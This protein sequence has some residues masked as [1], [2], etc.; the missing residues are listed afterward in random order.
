MATLKDRI[1]DLLSELPSLT[2]REITIRLMGP[3]VGQQA[4]NQATRALTASGK[5]I[6]RK[7]RDGKLGN[8]LGDPSRE[9]S[10]PTTIGTT[11]SE[12]VALSEDE[13]KLKL[14]KWLETKGWTVDVQLGR[15]RGIDVEATRDEAR[16]VIEA[17]GRG[18]RTQMQRNYF[19]EVLGALLL[20]MDDPNVR[21]SIALPDLK[22]FRNL[23]QSL[24]DLA[25][26]RT[27]ISA[28]FVDPFGSVEEMKSG[29]GPSV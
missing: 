23:W 6:R 5:L 28:L 8:Y 19:L 9:K 1:V 29:N 10:D 3:N 7:R 14:Q 12:S 26:S 13:L 15:N 24:P 17:K 16:W 4:V 11:Q 27:G 18:S 21:Y 20:R 22:R 25:K 2:D